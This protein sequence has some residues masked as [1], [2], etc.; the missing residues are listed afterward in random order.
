MLYTTCDEHGFVL[1]TAVTTNNVHDSVAFD[2][3]YDRMTEAFSKERD[4]SAIHKCDLHD[5]I[6]SQIL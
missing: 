4:F 5:V 2:E 3:V 1:E 6:I